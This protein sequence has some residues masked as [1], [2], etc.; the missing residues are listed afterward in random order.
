M[1]RHILGSRACIRRKHSILA[2]KADYSRTRE[3][4]RE[5]K[6]DSSSSS[7][8]RWPFFLCRKWSINALIPAA[9]SPLWK[10][11]EPS[12]ATSEKNTLDEQMIIQ[13]MEKKNSIILKWKSHPQHQGQERTLSLRH[14]WPTWAWLII[15]TW[16]G[17]HMKIRVLLHHHQHYWQPQVSATKWDH[18][19][20]AMEATATVYSSIS[21]KAPP[22]WPRPSPSRHQ[23]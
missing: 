7:F 3:V 11:F 17:Q 10:A 16:Q 12:K 4:G 5:S 21:I 18:F 8:P 20:A 13:M 23:W 9:G 14:K 2:L 19:P 1:F 15:W 22:L 6:S